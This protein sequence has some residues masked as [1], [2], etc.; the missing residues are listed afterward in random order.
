MSIGF[1]MTASALNNQICSEDTDCNSG[2]L[3]QYTDEEV[4]WIV[5]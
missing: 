1:E 4:D 5:E 3:A 2:N